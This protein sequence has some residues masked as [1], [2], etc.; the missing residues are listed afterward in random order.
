[1][2]PTSIIRENLPVYDMQLYWNYMK[3]I[4]KYIISNTAQA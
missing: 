3:I 4:S 1:M 2:L